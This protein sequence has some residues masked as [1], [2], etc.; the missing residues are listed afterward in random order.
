MNKKSPP[1]VPHMNQAEFLAAIAFTSGETG[2]RSELI[3]KDYFCSL[4]LAHFYSKENSPL[5]FRGGTCLNKVH[6]GF[7]RL[8]E[9]LDFLISSDTDLTRTERKKLA[10]PL[11]QI[12]ES[13]SVEVPGIKIAGALA[14]HND[15]RQYNGEVQYSS[16]ITGKPGRIAIEIGLR[17]PILQKAAPANAATLLKDPFTGKSV[18]PTVKVFSLSQNEAFAEK[19]RA[20][21]TR[22]DPAIRDF[23]DLDYA[24]RSKR[25]DLA[26]LGFGRLVQQKLAVPGT[27]PIILSENRLQTLKGQ[28][29]TQLQPVLRDEDFSL[30]DL[31]RVFLQMKNFREMFDRKEV[32]FVI[33]QI[34]K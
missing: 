16:Q 6:V 15:S 33:D 11:K 3:E 24:I 18:I 10:A 32:L 8:S 1:N 14:G 7:Y 4:L 2:F 22:R 23:F 21:L 17:E 27:S 26:D 28:I 29:D 20:A 13:L 19:V 34:P 12:M 5:I 25:I 9:D 31:E 30:F